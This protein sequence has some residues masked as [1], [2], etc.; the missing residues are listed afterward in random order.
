MHPTFQGDR[1]AKNHLLLPRFNARA[2]LV[3]ETLSVRDHRSS[4][5]ET[6][7]DAID[8]QKVS[9][10]RD[11]YDLRGQEFQRRPVKMREVADPN[12]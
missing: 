4:I 12:R 3:A 10:E 5:W 11:T 9:E 2:A 8:Q 6:L 7:D 1:R